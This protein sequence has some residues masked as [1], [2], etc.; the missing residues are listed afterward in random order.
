MV[1]AIVFDDVLD[2]AIMKCRADGMSWDDIAE[3]VG[4]DTKPVRRR[5]RELKLPMGHL[6]RGG[7]PGVKIKERE[8]HGTA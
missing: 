4:I 3:H 8:R 1:Q 6:N 5:G 2:R 7:I